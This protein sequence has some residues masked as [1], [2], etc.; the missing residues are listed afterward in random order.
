MMNSSLDI[1]R[2]IAVVV[3]DSPPV[4]ALGF[5][6]RTVL[7]ERIGAALDHPDVRGVVLTGSTPRAFSAGADIAEFGTA[8]STAFPSLND[9]IG[10][11]ENAHVPIVA[12]IGG[13]ALGGGMELALGCHARIASEGAK[14]GLPEVTLGLMPGAGGTQRLPRL[15]G[16]AAAR[17]F[18]ATGRPWRAAAA[19]RSGIVDAVVDGDLIDCAVNW[20][21]T[22]LESCPTLSRASDRALPASD[23]SVPA[24]A[25]P[26]A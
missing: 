22:R 25:R 6:L 20:L 14:L 12:A 21:A 18:I 15:I 13:F 24:Q 19:R 3:L 11:I 1:R 4:N 8:A 26:H 9:L 7:Y 17:S 16:R 23:D 10:R 2:G 5:T